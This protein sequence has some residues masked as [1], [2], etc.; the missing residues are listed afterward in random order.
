MKF[1]STRDSIKKTLKEIQMKKQF[2]ED[3]EM[4]RK[5][6]QKQKIEEVIIYYINQYYYRGKITSF[7]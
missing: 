1:Q 5:Y 4:Q 3:N 2:D 7:T 6:E